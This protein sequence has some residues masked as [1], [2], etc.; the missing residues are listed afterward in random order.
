MTA[1]KK[2]TGSIVLAAV[3]MAHVGITIATEESYIFSAADYQMSEQPAANSN[4]LVAL[5]TAG[6]QS[7]PSITSPAGMFSTEDAFFTF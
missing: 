1:M 2:L 5:P 6:V 3:L 4:S 7:Q